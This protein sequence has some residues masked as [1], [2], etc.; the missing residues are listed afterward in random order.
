MTLRSTMPIS[1]ALPQERSPI[2][3]TLSATT[4]SAQRRDSMTEPCC[5]QV[6]K[7]TAVTATAQSNSMFQEDHPLSAPQV[8]SLDGTAI[9]PRCFPMVP[10]CSLGATAFG[11][12]RPRAQKFTP[13]Q[14]SKI[15]KKVAAYGRR[16]RTGHRGVRTNSG[17]CCLLRQHL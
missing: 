16:V 4:N 6:A 3:E 9:P 11:R 14:G 13:L 7:K 15:A 2:S 17:C 10:C 5:L 8:C 12:I 1:I